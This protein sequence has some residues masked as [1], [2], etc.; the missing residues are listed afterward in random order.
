MLYVDEADDAPSSIPQRTKFPMN[1]FSV[2]ISDDV[3]DQVSLL[4]RELL[5]G[6]N[7]DFQCKSTSEL[8]I[9]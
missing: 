7:N 3:Y 8:L 6:K 4:G 2:P 1:R 9:F 5:C